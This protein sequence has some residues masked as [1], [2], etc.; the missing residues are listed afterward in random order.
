MAI[1]V[2][3]YGCA[4]ARM[5]ARTDPA[6]PD[7]LAQLWIEPADVEAR[8]LFDGPGGAALAPDASRPFELLATDATGYSRGYD[9]RDANGMEWSVKVGDEA[10]T[11]V[12]A[13]R[14][15]WVA[16]FHQPPTYYVPSWTMGTAG[17]QP[18]ARFR[19]TLPGQ[20]TASDWAWDD[21]PF[22]G[23]R[24]L[25]ALMVINVLINNWDWK[26]S[27]N[28]IYQFAPP[29][30]P[31]GRRYVVR[32]LGASFGSTR[33][34]PILHNLFPVMP[35]GSRNDLRGFERERFIESADDEHVDFD[36]HARNAGLLKQVRPHDVIW[37]CEL[38]SRLSSSQWSDA[39]RAGGYA[40]DEIA[41]F[42][43]AMQQRIEQGRTLAARG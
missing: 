11:E 13:S 39:F 4:S 7:E 31:P 12:V 15:L 22:V 42:V 19:P 23:T 5:P 27:N 43:R 6:R 33:F 8:N 9:V 37:I 28:K 41:R 21:N 18:P 20:T 32:D 3:A 30:S 2:L 36:Y 25:R 35:F 26:T 16:G 1:S 10:Q 14:V 17:T 24:E 29:A 40:P 38:L 34:V